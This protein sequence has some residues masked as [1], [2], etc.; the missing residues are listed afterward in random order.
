MRTAQKY[1]RYM[2]GGFLLGLA[3]TAATRGTPIENSSPGPAEAVAPTSIHFS[4]EFRQGPYEC[5]K[6]SID[7]Q[8][9]GKFEAKP[10]DGELITRDL[11]VT[12]ETMQ[13]LL[14]AFESA[15]FLSSAR[16]YESH[17]KVADMGMKTIMFERSGRSRE[18]R[19]NY[20][21]DRHMAAIADLLSGLVTTQ[22]RIDSL[23]KTMRYDKLGLPDQLN[24]LQGE[25][26]SRWLVDAEL[27]IPILTEIANNHAF[28]NIVQ[29]KAQQLIQQIESAKPSA[30]K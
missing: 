25:L 2:L 27:M 30:M 1:L 11:Q 16:D 22:L 12:V 9:R 18:V 3:L 8:G 28:F 5:F 21:L 13:R 15:Q 20:T 7:Q 6:I 4:K 29:R 17:M 24:A 14:A 10:R 26:N 23:E 19:F